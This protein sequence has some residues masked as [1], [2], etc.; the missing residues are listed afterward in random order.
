MRRGRAGCT[1]GDAMDC[2]RDTQAIGRQRPFQHP[3]KRTMRHVTAALYLSLA[4][5]APFLSADGASAKETVLY[6]FQ[7]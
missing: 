3:D 6:S 7:G 4:M 5:L 2:T 1:D